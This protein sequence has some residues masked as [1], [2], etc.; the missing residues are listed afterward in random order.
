MCVCVW[1]RVWCTAAVL[2]YAVLL[3]RLL[4]YS[5]AVDCDCFVGVKYSHGDFVVCTGSW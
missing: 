1:V 5:T 4:L 3:S 2:C